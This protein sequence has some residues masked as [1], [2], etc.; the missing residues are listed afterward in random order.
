[1]CI[2][3]RMHGCQGDGNSFDFAPV[4]QL[5]RDCAD[6]AHV[7]SDAEKKVLILCI[8][9]IERRGLAQASQ[10]LEQ[11]GIKRF[12]HSRSSVASSQMSGFNE[13]APLPCMILREQ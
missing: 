6:E 5:L 10:V 7:D 13:P 3:Q 11:F 4:H 9:S 12:R 2:A 8:E 1:M